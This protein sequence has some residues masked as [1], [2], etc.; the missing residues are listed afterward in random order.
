[1]LRKSQSWGGGGGGGGECREAGT[2]PFSEETVTDVSRR[3]GD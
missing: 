1:M 2:P 3:C